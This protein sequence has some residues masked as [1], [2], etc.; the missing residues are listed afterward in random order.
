M[1]EHIKRMQAYRD[2]LKKKGKLMEV[3]A[4]ERCIQLAREYGQPTH[5]K[6]AITEGT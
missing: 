6:L 2:R 4:V 5:P 3:R 1:D